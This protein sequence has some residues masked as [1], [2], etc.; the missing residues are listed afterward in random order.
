[1]ERIETVYTYAEWCRLVEKH[2]RRML[3]RYIKQKAVELL[4][5]AGVLFACY[6][7]GAFCFWVA[8]Q[9]NII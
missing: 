3:A 1:M 9:S 7:V 2:G 8:Y 4:T 6:L 5:F